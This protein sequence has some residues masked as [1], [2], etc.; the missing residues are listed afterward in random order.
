M[1]DDDLRDALREAGRLR[2]KS[3][4]AGF[5]LQYD[6][7]QVVKEERRELTLSALLAATAAVQR[8]GIPLMLVLCGLPT[9]LE[10]LGRLK[11]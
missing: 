8:E 6:E 4:H 1:L 10:N 9:I 2:Q 7:F 3:D 11:S 5:I